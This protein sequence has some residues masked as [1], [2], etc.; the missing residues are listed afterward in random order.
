MDV[1]ED[2]KGCNTPISFMVSLISL[3]SCIY[4]HIPNFLLITKI[5]EFHG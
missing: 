3:K 2:N 1:G 4:L 5:E